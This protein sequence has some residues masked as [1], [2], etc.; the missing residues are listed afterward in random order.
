MTE[1]DCSDFRCEA[2]WIDDGSAVVAIGGELD[3]LNADEVNHVIDHLHGDGINDHLV[4]DLTGCSFIDSVGLSV[5]IAAQHAAK[6]P[7]NVVIT[8]EALRRVFTVTG[9][10]SVFVLHETRAEAIEELRRRRET[11]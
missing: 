9:L 4:V 1:P 3:M 8:N 7:L 6:S 11:V 5:L 2:V 10:T